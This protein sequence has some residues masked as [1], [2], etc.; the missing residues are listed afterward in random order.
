MSFLLEKYKIHLSLLQR[1]CAVFIWIH[2]RMGQWLVPATACGKAQRVVPSLSLWD[3]HRAS[4]TSLWHSQ[5]WVCF[6]PGIV[7]EL[8]LA[9]NKVLAMKNTTSSQMSYPWILGNTHCLGENWR[10]VTANEKTTQDRR[11]SWWSGL[12]SEMWCD[13]NLLLFCFPE[14]W[15][16]PQSASSYS[17]HTAGSD[18]LSLP[19]CATPLLWIRKHITWTIWGLNRTVNLIQEIFNIYL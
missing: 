1:G 9:W 4:I 18:A 13:L 6:V 8:Y 16:R 3:Y 11:H 15:P 5:A 7:S 2:Y 17:F 10:G 19:T 14:L 12:A